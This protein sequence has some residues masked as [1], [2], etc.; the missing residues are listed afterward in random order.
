MTQTNRSLL[1]ARIYIM[2]VND[3]PERCTAYVN[4][5]SSSGLNNVSV[6]S[7]ASVSASNQPKSPA[8]MPLHTAVYL[9]VPPRPSRAQ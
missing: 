6:S 4:V 3:F 1:F 7:L 5:S 2:P 8:L 9:Y